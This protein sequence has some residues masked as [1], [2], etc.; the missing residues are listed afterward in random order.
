MLIIKRKVQNP[1]IFFPDIR[2]IE[3]QVIGRILI[4]KKIIS[5]RRKAKLSL[6]ETSYKTGIDFWRLWKYEW[7]IIEIPCN[8]IS[9]LLRLYNAS[10]VDIFYF[11]AFNR[12]TVYQE[13]KNSYFLNSLF[14][15]VSPKRLYN[16][17]KRLKN[18]TRP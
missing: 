1:G 17:I 6:L 5:L 2:K 16:S 18:R 13:I 10:E 14:L 4:S 15:L 7:G 8:K 3:Y 9:V 12:I 11:C